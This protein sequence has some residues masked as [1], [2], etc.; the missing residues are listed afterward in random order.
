MLNFSS[1]KTPLYGHRICNSSHF[2]V[3]LDFKEKDYSRR[4][5]LEQKPHQ[6]KSPATGLPCSMV[7]ILSQFIHIKLQCLLRNLK[8]N[9]GTVFLST[10][11]HIKTVAEE[12]KTFSNTLSPS[13]LN[14]RGKQRLKIPKEKYVDKRNRILGQQLMKQKQ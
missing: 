4:I 9:N 7:A 13:L 6:V 2:F 10:D 14:R 12:N 8:S 5:M 11:H 1:L 3:S